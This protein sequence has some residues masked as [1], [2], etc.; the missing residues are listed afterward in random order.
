MQ[1]FGVLLVVVQTVCAWGACAVQ[2]ASFWE[3]LAAD[4]QHP[5]AIACV[6]LGGAALA[7]GDFSAA[8]AI[9][10]LGVAVGGPVCFSC[11]LICGSVGDFALEG[12]ARPLVPQRLEPHL[13]APERL[14][15]R[16]KG[17]GGCRRVPF[18]RSL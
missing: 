8:A 18:E 6:V 17:A 7:V 12:S 13:V 10:K 16:G 15:I 9:E 5:L 14:P 11:M 2:G 1:P 3:G 4:S